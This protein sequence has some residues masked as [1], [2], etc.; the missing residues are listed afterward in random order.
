MV[1]I[2]TVIM[3]LLIKG[4]F[5][6][7]CICLMNDLLQGPEGK[8]GTPGNRGRH[9]KKVRAL[10]LHFFC[11][12][13]FPTIKQWEARGTVTGTESSWFS[14]LNHHFGQTVSCWLDLWGKNKVTSALTDRFVAEGE[15]D[16]SCCQKGLNA[17]FLLH[18]LPFLI[19]KMTFCVFSGGERSSRTCWRG[20][21]KRRHRPAR[22]GGAEGCQGNSRHTS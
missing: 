21:H 16:A 20:W 18:M 4:I 7:C 6:V 1:L 11:I 17:D 15:M 8:P 19:P 5:S 22:R 3:P 10:S 12:E 13:C 14:R 9:G 2:D